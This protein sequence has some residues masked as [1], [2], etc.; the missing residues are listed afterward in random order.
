MLTQVVKDPLLVLERISQKFTLEKGRELQVLK[1]ISVSLYEDEIVAFLGP[2]GCGKTTMLKIMAGLLRPSEGQVFI[3]GKS[4]R[5]INENLSFVFQ[6]YALLPWFTVEQNVS[7]GLKN[8]GLTSRQVR[9]RITE[10]MD[11][12][13][14]GGFEEAYPREL[15][16]G[17]RQRVGIARALAMRP[18]ILCLDEPFSSVDVLTAE[19]LRAEVVDIWKEK[20]KAV[21]SVVMVTHNISEAVVMAQRIFVFGTDP[22]HVR[23]VLTNPLPY[24]RDPKGPKFLELVD[25]IH[26][27]ITEALIPEEVE[28]PTLVQPSWYQG[29]ENL[30]DV[31]PS[32]IIGLMEVLDN[33]KGKID[34]FQLAT[35][36][37]SEFGHCLAVTKTAELLDFVDT[38]K[39]SVVFTDVGQRF[40]RADTA[41]KKELFSAQLRGLRIFQT[42]FSWL[43]ESPE[44]EISREEVIGKL[45][46]YFPN[47]KLDKLFDTIVAFGRYAEVISYNAQLGLLTWPKPEEELV[48]ESETAEPPDNDS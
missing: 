45:Q 35:E 36:T 29:L 16:G 38:P 3:H 14:L 28:R 34:I 24:P 40:M 8:M 9:L 10:G 33:A 43:D 11:M 31:S 32:E 37:A 22:G 26:A 44:K 23:T 20:S 1:N 42:L 41:E 7:L 12:V 47:E 2:S 46:V 18:E 48:P 15:S 25:V 30:P 27:V 39:Q 6:N 5:G 21:K 17:M 13:G 4:L 19:N